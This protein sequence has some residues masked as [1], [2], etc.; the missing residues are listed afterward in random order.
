MDIEKLLNEA[1]K[2]RM[3]NQQ[4]LAY[5]L[6]SENLDPIKYQALLFEHHPVWWSDIE[7]GIC[8]LSRRSSKDIDFLKEVW[9]NPDFTYSFHRH[10]KQLP[11]DDEN[12]RNILNKEN[13]ALIS[14]TRAMHWIVKDKY[15]EPWG[16]LSLTDISLI[17][18]RSEVLLG[19]LQGAPQGLAVAAMLILFQFYFKV[20]KFNKLQSL[21]YEDNY[22]SL[23]GT[24]HLGFKQE[25]YLK[26]HVIDPKSRKYVN[27]IQTGL[28]CNEAFTESNKRLMKRLL[29]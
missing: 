17:H 18:R 24:L 16:L 27:L 23:K 12:L 10:M 25:G 14:E 19:L 2:L 15:A 1:S 28:I 6:L 4:Q 8:K 5:N 9:K 20:I 7:A 3:R 13:S 22:H 26:E 11:S 29:S 21:I